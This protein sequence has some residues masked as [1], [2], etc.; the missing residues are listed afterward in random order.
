MLKDNH[1]DIYGSI[2]AAVKAAKALGGF[3]MKVEVE[4]RTLEDAIEALKAGAEIV[5]LDN[6]GAVQ[7]GQWAQS[8]KATFPH[9]IIEVSGGIKESTLAQFGSVPGLSC[10][11]IL[12][13]GTLTQDQTHIDF[14]L[15]VLK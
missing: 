12:S 5:M 15:K 6:A 7:A 9:A 3:T 13:M 4:C 14:S 10:I 1:I 2:S 8:I 11:D